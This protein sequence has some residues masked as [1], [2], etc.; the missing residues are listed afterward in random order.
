MRDNDP[1]ALEHYDCAALRASMGLR[2]IGSFGPYSAT[3]ASRHQHR[4]H[5]PV[6]P[7]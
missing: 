4:M 3:I 5:M 2:A 1:A 6:A 7:P